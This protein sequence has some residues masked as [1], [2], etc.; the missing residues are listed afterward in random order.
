L[1]IN[2]IQKTGTS[3]KVKNLSSYQMPEVR[4]LVMEEI[5]KELEQGNNSLFAA[6]IVAETEEVYTKTV[7]M[8]IKESIQIPRLKIQH[9]EVVAHFDD[10]DLDTEGFNYRILDK[11]IIR[12]NLTDD[13][14]TDTISL[15]ETVEKNYKSLIISQLCTYP[16]IDYLQYSKLI[17]KLVRQAIESLMQIP[18][19][20][21]NIGNIIKGF[22][23]PIAAEI[24][25]QMKQHFHLEEKGF[26]SS[27]AHPFCVLESWNFSHL[28]NYGYQ[29]YDAVINPTRDIDKYIYKGFEKAC[30][31]EY[32][33]DSKA[34]KD[35]ATILEQD[36]NVKKWLRPA[37]SQ[38]ELYYRAAPHEP[39]KKYEPDFVVETENKIYIVEVKS[40][41]VLDDAIVLA[42]ATSA[43]QYCKEVSTYNASNGGKPWTYLLVPPIVPPIVP[44]NLFGD[45]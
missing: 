35:F 29:S 44:P 19:D 40:V 9:Q 42:K 1:I 41:A 13:S 2:A 30:H 14:T 3:S 38:F 45:V 5:K 15:E 11:N 23:R 27:V 20:K 4:A 24:Y 22:Y 16:E 32:K 8:V 28:K 7:A 37:K 39:Q 34:E 25:K 6:S 33:F 10:F 43:L 12:I 36:A 21:E 31:A 26:Y 18:E 17:Q